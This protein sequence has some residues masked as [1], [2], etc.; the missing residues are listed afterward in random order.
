MREDLDAHARDSWIVN[1]V[2]SPLNRRTPMQTSSRSNVCRLVTAA[3]FATLSAASVANAL[4]PSNTL[5]GWGQRGDAR[6][7][8]SITYQANGSL[9]GKLTLV[10][11]NGINQPTV[12]RYL[13]FQP[14]N[15][16]GGSWEFNAQGTCWS[17]YGSAPAANRFSF[18]DNGSPGAGIDTVD[19]NYYGSTGVAIPGGFFSDGDITFTP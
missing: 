6:F 7:M 19:V 3:V 17:Q 12:C 10:F 2:R 8:G 18:A 15:I 1:A 11:D 9:Q 4:S 13:S 14:L 5:S 16:N